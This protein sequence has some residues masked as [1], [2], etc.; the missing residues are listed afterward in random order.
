MVDY[1]RIGRRIY[2][3]RKVLR[4]LSQEKMAEDLGMFQAD[5]SN[6]EKAKKGSGITDLS[7]LDFIADYFGIPLESLIFGMEGKYMEAYTGSKMALKL[8]GSCKIKKEHKDALKMLGWDTQREGASKTYVCG[9]YTVYVIFEKQSSIDFEN[10]EMT[11]KSPIFKAHLYVFYKSE[12]VATMMT[13]LT[14]L[15]Q[16][17]YKPALDNLSMMIPQESIDVYDIWRTLNPY[18]TLMEFSENHEQEEEYMNLL[19]ARMDELKKEHDTLIILIQSAYVINDCRRKGMLRMMLDTLKE[20][21]GDESVFWANLEPTDGSELSGEYMYYPI[22]TKAAL[23]QM[24]EN[25]AIAEKLGFTVDPWLYEIAFY[26]DEDEIET[27]LDEKREIDFDEWPE[28]EIKQIYKYAFKLNGTLSTIL[29]EDSGLVEKS[30]IFEKMREYEIKVVADKTGAVIIDHMKYV[31][32]GSRLIEATTA[33]EGL[34]DSNIVY[35]CIVR[36]DDN[37]NYYALNR[38]TFEEQRE[39]DRSFFDPE[40]VIVSFDTEEEMRAS[41]YKDLFEAIEKRL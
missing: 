4:H 17:V 34:T 38:N 22:F 11:E 26:P 13:V 10:G 23:G 29:K 3:E 16:Y 25:A 32:I 39:N 40:N 12:V 21:F 9:P 27:A 30:H 20:E 33:I 24:N 7:K 41:M 18:W 19:Y 1:E 31:L 2:E 14:N 28:P 5:I 6:L 36:Y 15:M 8:Y 35:A 37:R